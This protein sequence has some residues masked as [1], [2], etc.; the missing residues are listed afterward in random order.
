[1]AQDLITSLDPYN[2]VCEKYENGKR[3][4]YVILSPEEVRLS[5]AGVN[6]PQLFNSFILILKSFAF[7][8]SFITL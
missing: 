8:A 2:G 5:I 1:M 4:M 7:C 6:L 3:R